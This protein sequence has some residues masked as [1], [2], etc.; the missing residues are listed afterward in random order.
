[1]SVSR[2]FSL[3]A[4]S[5]T[6][7]ADGTINPNIKPENGYNFEV[8]SKVYLFNK[9]LYT[10]VAVYRMEIKDLLVAQRVGNDQYV[11]MNAGKTLHEGVEW[12]ARYNQYFSGN[13]HLA[14]YMAT[15]FG[16]YRFEE[17]NNNGTDYSGNK[18]TGVPSTKVNAGFTLGMPLRLYLSA[19]YYYT[20]SL[21]MNDANTAFANS[22]N[23]LNAKIGWSYF[24]EYGLSIGA[25]FGINNLTD[26]HYASMVL[27][28]ATGTNPR[29]YYPG[30]PVNYYGNVNIS[31]V[32]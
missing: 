25:S 29:Y 1:A 19:D 21:P 5:E 15:S 12:S 28:N 2:G 22:Y 11:G 7:N 3:P 31:Y 4:I 24:R 26:T 23:L 14:P 30:L 32:F 13:W 27:V 17:F 9:R 6:L 10:D 18:L 16:R 20:G 8:G